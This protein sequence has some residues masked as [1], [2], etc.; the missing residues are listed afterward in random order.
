MVIIAGQMHF[1]LANGN[2]E[3]EGSRLFLLLVYD[4]ISTN[5]ASAFLIMTKNL[6]IDLCSEH[7][8]DPPSNYT[9]KVVIPT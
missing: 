3:C 8:Y 6:Y 4:S 9:R 5:S 2:M 1:L 7:L